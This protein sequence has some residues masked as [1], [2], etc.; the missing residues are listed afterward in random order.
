MHALVCSRYID[1]DGPTVKIQRK[2]F[3][4]RYDGDLQYCSAI[5]FCVSHHCVRKDAAKLCSLSSAFRFGPGSGII[6]RSRFNSI[7]TFICSGDASQD[8][9]QSIEELK[10]SEVVPV[11]PTTHSAGFASGGH[12][13]AP[14]FSK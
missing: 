12:F 1:L 9:G 10:G 3:E 6:S 11:R 7:C 13:W 14:F 4:Y 2:A 5:L 8:L